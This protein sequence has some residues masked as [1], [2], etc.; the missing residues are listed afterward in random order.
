MSLT[1]LTSSSFK[2]TVS[3][4]PF[5]VIDFWAP[6]CGPCRRFGPIFEEVSARHSDVVFAKVNTEDQPELASA[7]GIS[8]I[9][10][11]M[12]FRNH[13][14]VYSEAG[15]LSARALEDLIKQTREL[16]VEP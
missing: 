10:T 2:Q 13:T 9:P 7:M 14:Q 16:V 3:E 8:A 1:E 5:V 6:W 4:N 12:I 15:A 11:L